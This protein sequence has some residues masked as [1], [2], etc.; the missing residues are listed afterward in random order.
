MN[1]NQLNSHKM[2]N[3]SI[4]ENIELRKYNVIWVD[5]DIDALCPETGTNGMKKWIK[6]HRIEVIGRAR[7]FNQFENMM[8][9]C[10]DRV[11][12][13]IT[14]ANFSDTNVTA[15][16]EEYSGLVR[17]LEV[18]KSFNQ[19]RDIPF[20]L[21]TGKK[22]YIEKHF[23]FGQLDY[24]KNNHRIF[25]KGEFE[26]MF[27]QLQRD[28]D[29]INSP[30]Y[31]VRNKYGKYLEA[32]SFIEGNEKLIWDALMQSYL[33]EIKIQHFNSLR[34]VVEHIFSECANLSILPKGLSSL[35][36]ICKFLNQGKENNYKI[37][38]NLEIMPKPLSRALWYFLD[39]TQDGSHKKSDLKLGVEKYARE[40]D[41]LNIFRSVLFIAMDICFWY[42]SVSEEAQG[43]YTPKWEIIEPEKTTISDPNE[44]TSSDESIILSEY[45]NQIVVLEQDENKCWFYKKCVVRI[46]EWE[47][48]KKIKLIDV[49]KNRAQNQN[50]YPYISRFEIIND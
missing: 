47:P 26:K 28:V 42:K 25:N 13:V 2:E 22:E 12:A 14:D 46:R 41:S 9:Y 17:M 16:S 33:G 40:T 50:R 19:K 23:A 43:D 4:S 31:I 24:F 20:Y 39:I 30:S 45:T 6:K 18:I 36:G 48:G 11:D 35:N 15:H 27:I 34:E 38:E 7:S 3:N 44:S 1:A 10:Y 5:D 29:H 32:A 8:N 37:K 49:E 21:Y